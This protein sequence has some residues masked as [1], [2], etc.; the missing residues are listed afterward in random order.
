MPRGN[1]LRVTVERDDIRSAVQNGAAVT[2]SAECSVENDL[3]APRL[4]RGQDLA[5]KNRDVTHW[6]ATGAIFNAARVLCHPVS[7]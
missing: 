6:S 4:Q 3:S 1:R 5:Q 2:A 7:P